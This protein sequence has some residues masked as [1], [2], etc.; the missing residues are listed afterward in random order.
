MYQKKQG[1]RGYNSLLAKDRCKFGVKSEMNRKFHKICRGE[2][3][4]VERGVMNAGDKDKCWGATSGG[5]SIEW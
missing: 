1:E 5:G 2:V 4:C 3:S